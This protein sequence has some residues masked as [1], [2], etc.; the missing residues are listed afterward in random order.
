MTIE[1][2]TIGKALSDDNRL[3]LL[4]A[5]RESEICVCQLVALVELAPSTVSKHLQVLRDAGMLVSRKDGRWMH[6][7]W[8]DRADRTPAVHDALR[9]VVSAAESDG[10]LQHDAK[11][12]KA[13]CS[14]DAED[15]CRM[16]RDD[17]GCCFSARATRAAAKWPRASRGRSTKG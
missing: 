4:A 9:M 15:L 14:I 3:R 13:I 8:P 5:C 2:A 10:T 11:R 7:R 16:Q 1:L 17:P 12:L 6:Y